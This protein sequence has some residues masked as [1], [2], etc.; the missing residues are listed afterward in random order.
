MTHVGEVNMKIKWDSIRK[1]TGNSAWHS[2]AACK[3]T[4]GLAIQLAVVTQPGEKRETK[5]SVLSSSH[6]GSN[7]FLTEWLFLLTSQ[8]KNL[9]N[10]SHCPMLLTY[11]EQQ[12]EPAQHKT[13]EQTEKLNSEWDLGGAF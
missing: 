11:K 5:D 2:A 7:T 3:Q 12:Q 13:N 6:P 10:L 4:H 8:W 1:A 9:E